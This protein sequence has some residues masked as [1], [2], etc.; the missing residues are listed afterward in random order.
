[1]KTFKTRTACPFRS[2]FEDFRLG[3]LSI[4]VNYGAWHVY[5]PLFGSSVATCLLSCSD[6]SLLSINEKKQERSVGNGRTYYNLAD[7]VTVLAQLYVLYSDRA[8]SFNPCQRAL[9]LDLFMIM[10]D[11]VYSIKQSRFSAYVDD[12]NVL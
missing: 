4:N 6:I 5:K 11:L 9:Y 7:G 3:S 12:S 10:T 8:R 2:L 1:M